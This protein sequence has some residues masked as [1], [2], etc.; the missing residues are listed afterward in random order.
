MATSLGSCRRD[1]EMSLEPWPWNRTG[2]LGGRF[3]GKGRA[4][5]GMAH[6][7]KAAFSEGA[8]EWGTQERGVKSQTTTFLSLFLRSWRMFINKPERRNKNKRE[9]LKKTNKQVIYAETQAKYV[10]PIWLKDK[11]GREI[12][13]W[14]REGETYG[15]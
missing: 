6:T 12:Y 8:G 4:T 1:W 9:M 11:E 14:M 7:V 13:N 3:P 15:G 10:E 5:G 2:G